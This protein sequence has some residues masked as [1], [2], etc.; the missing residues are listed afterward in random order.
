MGGNACCMGVLYFSRAQVRPKKRYIL[1]IR[2]ELVV[3]TLMD[4]P[5]MGW[6]SKAGLCIDEQLNRTKKLRLSNLVQ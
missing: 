6:I 5:F 4:V 3:H 1:Q 2:T